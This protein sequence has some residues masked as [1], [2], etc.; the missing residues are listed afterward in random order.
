LFCETHRVLLKALRREAEA[1][2][3]TIPGSLRR[4]YLEPV[5]KSSI[6]YCR[7]PKNAS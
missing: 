2:L 4:R 5:P 7:T 6:F 1:V 3:A